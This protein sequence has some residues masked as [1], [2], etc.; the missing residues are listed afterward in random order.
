MV[1]AALEGDLRADGAAALAAVLEV[2][3][4]GEVD[5]VERFRRLRR[6]DAPREVRDAAGEWCRRIPD[7]PPRPTSAMPTGPDRDARR[8]VELDEDIAR[9]V[10][11]GYRDRLA[12]RRPAARTD[13]RGREQA[14]YQ[15]VG[16]GEVALRPADHPLSR[17][18]WLAVV[19]L[20]RGADGTAG[21]AQLAVAVD[22]QVALDAVADLVADRY[23]A[24]WDPSARQVTATIRRTVGAITLDER[25]WRDPSPDLVR[26]A[27]GVGVRTH[28]PAGVFDRWSQADELLARLAVVRTATHAEA[29]STDT[30]RSAIA[31][32]AGTHSVATEGTGQVAGLDAVLD[33]VAA[34]GRTTRD[35]LA[36]ID[37]ARYLTDA[38]EWHERQA[39]DDLAPRQLEMSNGRRLRV[40]YGPDGPVI[41]TRLQ[42]L[43]GCD[44][45]PTVGRGRVPVTLELLSPAGRPLQRTA[46][47][48]GFW[49]GSYSAVRSDM[50]GRY[51]KHRWPER[52]WE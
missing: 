21:W 37:V 4:P 6:G 18:R 1:L 28:G 44:D 12:R 46:D 26:S 35:Q 39:L 5:L 43:L 23:D 27:L 20:D 2:D 13:D 52:P 31:W 33:R 17:S 36:T 30:T 10:V 7:R 50:R 32:S 3:L 14:V 16:G 9:A 38:L 45:H 40:A 48:P 8:I 22:D 41:A 25:P 51:P 47:L 29:A 24:T 11:A 34:T 15:L 19:G 42:D 49:R